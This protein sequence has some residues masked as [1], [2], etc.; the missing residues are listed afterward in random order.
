MPKATLITTT[1]LACLVLALGCGDR[2]LQQPAPV[3]K[4]THRSTTIWS[5]AATPNDVEPKTQPRPSPAAPKPTMSAPPVEEALD[6]PASAPKP[7]PAT[8]RPPPSNYRDGCGRP[9]VA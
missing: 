7:R 3:Q 9:L 8:P 1:A 4:T 2:P 5:P 6:A